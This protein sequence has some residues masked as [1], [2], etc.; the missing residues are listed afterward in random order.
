MGK[1]LLEIWSWLFFQL[2]D[3]RMIRPLITLHFYIS[4]L[5][6]SKTNLKK[7][8]INIFPLYFTKE[9]Y[10]FII[11]SF[12]KYKGKY[13]KILFFK[14]DFRKYRS[15]MKKWRVV[16]GRPF[17]GLQ[18][19]K[20]IVIISSIISY[21]HTQKHSVCFSLSYRDIAIFGNH[22]NKCTHFWMLKCGVIFKN[23]YSVTSESYF[24]VYIYSISIMKIF[25]K[26]Q[27]VNLPKIYLASCLDA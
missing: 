17:A 3:V 4:L 8:T 18:A 11:N 24:S 5:D 7:Q 2:V 16:K 9:C 21:P 15:D 25:W 22:L 13:W 10:I 19:E 6:F 14:I 20:R 26:V 12:V 1:K 27:R 23:L